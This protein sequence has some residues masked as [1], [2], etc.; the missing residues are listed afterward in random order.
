ML[1]QTLELSSKPNLR[2]GAS[3]VSDFDGYVIVD[4]ETTGLDPVLD[5]ILE[6][7]ILIADKNFN[8]LGEFSMVRHFNL[9]VQGAGVIEKVVDMHTK[10]GLWEECANS[11]NTLSHISQS[12]TQWLTWGDWNNQPMCG[13]TIQFDRSFIA[14]W[15]PGLNKTFHYRHIDVS[16]FK[17]VWN[18]YGWSQHNTGYEKQGCHRAVPDCRDTLDELERYVV[19][20][21]RAIR[22]EE[23]MDHHSCEPIKGPW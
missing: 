16:S 4:V 1:S 12:A 17:N 9:E 14:Q 7:G 5:T 20:I 18:K 13:S 19:K 15:M 23:W 8:I 11:G 22:A 10:N 3:D 6:L 21:N 2:N